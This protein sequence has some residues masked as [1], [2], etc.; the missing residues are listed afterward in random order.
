MKDRQ[1]RIRRLLIGSCWAASASA[2]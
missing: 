1:R 2:W